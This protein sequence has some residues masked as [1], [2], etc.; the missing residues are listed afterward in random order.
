MRIL[1]ISFLACVYSWPALA[2]DPFRVSFARNESPSNV[3]IYVS[4]AIPEGCHIYAD[5][6]T[7][8]R[9]GGTAFSRSGGDLPVRI[10]DSFSGDERDVYAQDVTLQYDVGRPGRAGFDFK[11]TYQ[12]CNDRE[13]FFP[14][15]RVFRVEGEKEPGAGREDKPPAGGAPSGIWSNGAGSHEATARAAGYLKVSDFLELLDHAEGRETPKKSGLSLFIA[16]PVDFLKE[17]GSV[18]TIL[19]ILIGGLLLNLTPCVLPM[20]PINLAILGVGA[21]DSTRMRGFILGSAY[22]AGIAL[23]YG[24]LGLVVVLTGSQF[25]A[26]NSMPWFNGAIGVLFVILALAMFDV[27]A[28]DLTRFQS[29]SVGNP[30]ASRGGVV[31][32]LTIGG[33]AALLAGACVAPVVIAVL[34]LSGNLYAQGAWIGVVLPFVLGLG[35]ALPWPLAGAGLSCL[36]KPGTWMTWVKYGFGV[37]ILLFS[38]Y[39]FS[40][41]YTGWKGKAAVQNDAA[42]VVRLTAADGGRWAEVLKESAHTGKPVLVDFW[43]T[44]CKNCEVMELTTFRDAG[45]RER[46]EK[47]FI[48]VK[49]QAE[50]LTDPATSAVVQQFDVKGLPTYVIL[51]PKAKLP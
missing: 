18:W 48:V 33:V 31:T 34:L 12:G 30:G 49:F 46:L 24:T 38:A 29:G 19:L 28:I 41:A 50:N 4:I 35:M 22:G 39:Y 47:N 6:I 17:K 25:G 40:L 43:A 5:A 15:T 11:F 45:V 42:G 10:K 27:F 36:P 1:L 21:Q 3:A 26:L 37:L 44:W 16:N 14:K 51:K 9:E 20:I 32:A 23:V 2:A 8:E 13:C 7:A